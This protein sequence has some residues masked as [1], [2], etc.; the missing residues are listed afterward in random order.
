[1]NPELERKLRTLRLSGM[2]ASLD[3]RNQEAISHQLA[4]TDFL[5][6]KTIAHPRRQGLGEL[7]LVI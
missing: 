5:P 3:T 7:R 1:M 4:F 6:V 2:V